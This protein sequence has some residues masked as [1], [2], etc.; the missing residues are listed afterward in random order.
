MN[1]IKQNVF[2][3]SLGALLALVSCGKAISS[4]PSVSSSE[5][6]LS[7]SVSSSPLTPTDQTLYEAEMSKSFAFFWDYVSSNKSS[8]AYGLVADRARGN[9]ASTA[10]TG[11]GLAALPI[12]VERGY[13]SKADAEAR[14]LITLQ[15]V[16][17]LTNLHGFYWHFIMMDD[18][19]RSGTSEVSIID[20]AILVF[21]GLL[22]GAY[23]GGE[24]QTEAVKL[25]SA[26]DWTWFL[27]SHN[28]KSQFRMGYDPDS[29]SFAGYWDYYAEQ[30][31]LYILGAGSPTEAYR[32]DLATY[33]GFTRAKGSYGKGNDFIYSWFG[34]LFTYQY[35]LGFIDFRN[36]VDPN[37]VSWW[38]N[39]VDASKAAYQWCVDK[40]G[41]YETYSEGSWGL[42]AC[43]TRTGYN[44]YLGNKPRG[45]TSDASYESNAACTIAPCGA[46]GSMPFTPEYS[47]Q[48]LRNYATVDSLSGKYGYYDAY[49]LVHD[50]TATSY[51]GIDKGI[52]LL[53]MDNYLYGT[54]WKLSKTISYVQDGLSRLG[55]TEVA[56]NG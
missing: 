47:L 25:Y 50:W 40:K 33:N 54:A 38:Q 24:V 15:N 43:D 8:P 12:G 17:K 3:L 22:S 13:V 52:T 2:L 39:S 36:L 19:T 20:T 11:F 51:I 44:G 23:F 1:R 26:V 4:S 31:M 41:D 18:G 48:A 14:A 29:A 9:I 28:G 30:L 56:N 49:D 46:L 10:S 45:W 21:G 53:M 35:S 7:S 16:N 37:G 27:G 6:P 5:V 55:F 32:T 42:T 34:S